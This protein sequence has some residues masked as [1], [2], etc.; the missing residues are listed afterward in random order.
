MLLALVGRSTH[1]NSPPNSSHVWRLVHR[2]NEQQETWAASIQQ[3]NQV[4][5]PCFSGYV[6]RTLCLFLWRHSLFYLE[7]PMI[8][9]F[10]ALILGY[11]INMLLQKWPWGWYHPMPLLYDRNCILIDFGLSFPSSPNVYDHRF[12][13]SSSFHLFKLLFHMK[14]LFTNTNRMVFQDKI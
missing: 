7:R 14:L 1:L 11:K 6:Q 10:P 3:V 5:T 9:K 4:C 13:K 8:R 2:L 12:S